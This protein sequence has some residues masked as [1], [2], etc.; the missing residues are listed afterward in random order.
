MIREKTPERFAAR[1]GIPTAS[2]LGAVFS[3]QRILDCRPLNDQLRLYVLT[4]RADTKVLR[5]TFRNE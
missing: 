2:P 1:V 4:N 5:Y 3:L